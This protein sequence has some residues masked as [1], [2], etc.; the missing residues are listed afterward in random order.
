MGGTLHSFSKG[1]SE[2]RQKSVK[3]KVKEIKGWQEREATTRKV[4]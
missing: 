3:S 2:M 4:R 1:K